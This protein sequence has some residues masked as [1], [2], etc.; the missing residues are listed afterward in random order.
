MPDLLKLA[1]DVIIARQNLAAAEAA[2]R[3]AEGK[4]PR[5]T[6]PGPK[7]V[8]S[9]PISQ[10]VRDLLKDAKKPLTFRE[11]VNLLGGGDIEMAVRSAIKNARAKGDVVFKGGLYSWKEGKAGK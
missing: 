6:K 2:F 7:G 8:P 4:V 9:V 5:A 10:R 1:E 3:A 11:V